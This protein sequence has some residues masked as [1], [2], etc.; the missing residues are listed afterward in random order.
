MFF[1]NQPQRRLCMDARPTKSASLPI[2]LRDA[3]PLP[4][5][6]DTNARHAKISPP[7]MANPFYCNHSVLRVSY[8]MFGSVS[9]NKHMFFPHSKSVAGCAQP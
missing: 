2:P 9:P 8:D 6:S 4:A 1:L 7:P 3:L 5:N